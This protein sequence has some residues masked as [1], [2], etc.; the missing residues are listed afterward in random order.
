MARQGFRRNAKTIGH[1]L[2]TADGGKRAIAA[3]ILAEMNDSEAFIE[4]YMT[5]REVIGIV[6]PADK[7]A[8]N[9][10]ATK[11]ASAAGISPGNP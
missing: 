8:K 10:V 9:G 7:Q 4:E 3:K 6:V 11:A 5:D 2:K 1:I